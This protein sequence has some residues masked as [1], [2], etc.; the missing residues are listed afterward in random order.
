MPFFDT[1]VLSIFRRIKEIGTLVALGLTRT[2]VVLLFTIEGALNAVLAGLLAF[3]YGY[4]I[5]SRFA[6]AGWTMPK[7]M[8]SYGYAL[9]ERLMPVF[10][11]GLI[12]GTA[13]LIMV[14]TTVVSFLPV[15]KLSRLK[16]T[17]ALRGRMQ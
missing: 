15:R 10:G 1:Q 17:D 12:V 14:I 5:L 7:A 16:P 3:I 8:D 11:G 4:P 6:S 13:L 9:G 2:Q